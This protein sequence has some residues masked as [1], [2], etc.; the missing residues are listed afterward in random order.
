[1]R[2]LYCPPCIELIF[3]HHTNNCGY[4]RVSTPSGVGIRPA[5]DLSSMKDREGG[6]DVPVRIAG[7]VVPIAS[8]Q[9]SNGAI[10]AIAEPKADGHKGR[11]SYAL[12]YLNIYFFRGSA[13]K[14]PLCG[15]A[16]RWQE[17]HG[18]PEGPVRKAGNAVPIAS[19][20]ASNGATAAIAEPTADGHNCGLRR[21]DI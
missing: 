10:V 3:T 1:M 4:R 15:Y 13:P 5:L 20:Q 2:P 14:S 6:P 21:I 17:K 18:G 11:R 19:A 9:A 8:A 16:D 12:I 7:N